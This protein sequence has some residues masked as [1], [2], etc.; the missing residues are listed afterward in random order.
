MS[1]RARA[2]CSTESS[3]LPFKV[4]GFMVRASLK[5]VGRMRIMVLYLRQDE[6]VMGSVDMRGA[7]EPYASLLIVF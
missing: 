2:S 3:S 6:E 5:W 1:S 7:R 4:C